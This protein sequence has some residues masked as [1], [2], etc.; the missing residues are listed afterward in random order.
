MPAI[1]VEEK[2]G[3]ELVGQRGETIQSIRGG[4][5]M[6]MPRTQTSTLPFSLKKVGLCLFFANAENTESMIDCI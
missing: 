3:T 4:Q 5:S 6:L 1:S 2:L